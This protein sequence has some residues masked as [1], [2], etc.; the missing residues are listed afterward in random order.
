MRKIVR[1][2]RAGIALT[3]CPEHVRGR[4]TNAHYRRQI[5]EPKA[6]GNECIFGVTDISK[7]FAKNTFPRLDNPFWIGIFL[8]QAVER[9][10]SRSV[11]T[12]FY[13]FSRVFFRV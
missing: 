4:Y 3:Q 13:D 9:F 12:R 10:I 11:F 8:V 6:C 5:I 2:S 7:M 1:L